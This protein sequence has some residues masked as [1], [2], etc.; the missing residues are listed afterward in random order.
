[1][2][3]DGDGNGDGI[4][5]EIGIGA[6]GA[7]VTGFGETIGLGICVRRIGP[8]CFRSTYSDDD[9]EGILDFQF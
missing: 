6:T 3:E 5:G 8:S 7:L 1:V 9:E 2:D 4:G